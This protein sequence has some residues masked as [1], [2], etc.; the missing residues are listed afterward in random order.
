MSRSVVCV[1]PVGDKCGEGAVWSSDEA[2]LYWCDINRFLVHRYDNDAN[3][4]QSWL[5]NEPV[6]AVSLTSQ[7]GR[8]LLALA[9]KLVWWW[10][11]TDRREDHGFK[12]PGSPRVRLNDGRADPAGN[13]W[14]G[15][16]RNN[17]LPNGDLGETGKGEGILYRITPGGSVT[18]WRAGLGISNTLC[19]SP[20]QSTFYFGDTL[21]NTIYAYDYAL[22]AGGI[23][24]ERRFQSDFIRGLPDGSA[25]D[26]EGFLWNCR[27]GGSCIAR[28]SP[29]GT[30]AEIIEMPVSN[31]TTCTFGGDDLKT[32][33]ITSA[34]IL[35]VPG[36]RLAGSLFAIQ[37][38]VAGLPEN[39]I[40]MVV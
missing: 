5:F 37:V 13:F 17:V 38:D 33:Y 23:A 14:V 12:L 3:C 9:S 25:M 18:Q 16:M 27:F 31:V 29:D 26:S 10:P 11:A 7:A 8:F 22:S 30:I 39:R 6:V 21:E 19:W 40:Q 15:S 28:M 20:D 32:L 34:S 24:N 1:A 35:P 36:E 2:A 4:V